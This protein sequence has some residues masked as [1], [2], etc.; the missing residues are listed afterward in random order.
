M[1]TLFNFIK[2]N[3]FVIFIL[4]ISSGVYFRWLSFSIFTYGDGGFQF[5]DTLKEIPG[6]GIWNSFGLGSVNLLPWR[7]VGPSSLIYGLFG[8]LGFNSNIADKFIMNWPWII[9]SVISSFFL[10]RKITKSDIGGLI[11]SFVF[12]F[13]TYFL[14]INTQGQLLLSTASFFAVF[15]LL[16]FIKSLEE[17]KIY[18]IILTALFLFFTGANDF[19]MLY[20]AVWLIFFYFL[21][22]LVLRKK[23]LNYKIFLRDVLFSISPI[24]ILF[25]LNIF[26]IATSFKTGTLTNNDLFNR[27]LFGSDYFDITKAITLFH[28]FWNGKQPEWFVGQSIPIYFWLIPFFAFLGLLLNRRNRNVLFFGF[29]SLLGIFLAKQVSEPLGY[30]YK[31]LF[32]NFPL[33]NAFREASKFYFLIALGYSVLIGEFAA[34]LW[35]NWNKQKWQIYG[36]Y[37]LIFLISFVFL[38]NAKPIITGEIGSM[39]VPRQIPN[40]Y[41]VLKDYIL[42]QPE[43]FR[44]FWTPN[45]PRWAIYTNEKPIISDVNVIGREWEKNVSLNPEYINLPVNE[46]ITEI[47]KIKGANELF[48]IS[49]IK[50]VIVPIRDFTN[51]DDF[52]IY[53]GGSENA[54]IRER[55][56]SELDK[57][58]WLK[59]IDIGT[60]DLVVYENENFKP[61]IYMT[62]E[63]ETIYQELPYEKVDFEQ[64]NPSRYKVHLKNV[65]EPFYLNFSE[66]YHPDWKVEIGN[67]NWFSAILG[68]NYFLKGENHMKNNAGLNSF[69]I[70]PGYVCND[71]NCTKNEDGSYNFDLTLYFKPQSYFYLG[72]IISGITLIGITG[73]LVYDFKKRRKLQNKEIK[74]NE[75]IL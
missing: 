74:K 67:F 50:Y 46:Q 21:C 65:S 45:N 58:E 61:H 72:L 62:K 52:F 70:D 35:Q 40:D 3:K 38:W 7:L 68:K 23:P 11:G 63:R 48:D 27:T 13:N 26:W 30:I 42:K 33:F 31:W 24:I 29:V 22:F 56:I 10:V 36:K 2:K 43:Y 4:L 53:Y 66:S 71:N 9:L 49:S 18:L 44:T 6:F 73:Y 1:N 55:Y 20:I 51:D 47:F 37:L 5:F 19:R 60:K 75:K 59:K 54:N 16:F 17:K 28:P 32:E 64:K 34:W 57:V 25:L 8:I 41:L 69:Y 15:S 14:A 12:S 39:F